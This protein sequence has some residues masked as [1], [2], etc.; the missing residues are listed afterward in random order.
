MINQIFDFIA[1]VSRVVKY[2]RHDGTPLITAGGYTHNF[3]QNKTT[4]ANEFNMLI[5]AGLLSFQAIADF[6]VDIMNEL[7][8]IF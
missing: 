8:Y 1:S 3:S 5:R 4:C 2:F 7:S 6:M